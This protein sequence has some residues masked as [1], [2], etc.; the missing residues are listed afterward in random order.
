M[1]CTRQNFQYLFLN[2]IF[3]F[4][5]LSLSLFWMTPCRGYKSEKKSSYVVR[6]PSKF[7]Y[8]H[9]VNVI[10]F[11]RSFSVKIL[12]HIHSEHPT[13]FITISNRYIRYSNKH[14]TP[15]IWS[16]HSY[17]PAFLLRSPVQKRLRT[18]VIN[19]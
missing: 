8:E 3:L 2:C 4:L 18:P 7:V 9:P 11:F 19:F 17:F 15:N 1:K 12:L 16:H 6:S 14:S 5:Y 13:L 10:P